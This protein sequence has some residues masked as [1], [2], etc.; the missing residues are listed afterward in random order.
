MKYTKMFSS[1]VA[2]TMALM[3]SLGASTASATT[4]Y[5]EGRFYREAMGAGSTLSFSSWGSTRL[6]AGSTTLNTC[7]WGGIGGSILSPGGSGFSVDV[8]LNSFSWENCSSPTYTL[9][10]GT[11]LIDYT[12]YTEAVVHSSN[13]K[14]TVSLFGTSCV[15]GTG[16]YFDFGRLTTSSYGSATLNI[17]STVKEQEPLKWICPDT[18]V[19]TGTYRG[20]S[21]YSLWVE[22]W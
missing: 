21:P 5:K 1:I 17:K 8:S 16:T 13:F 6:E 9:A 2:V 15:Y 12:I 10:G 18:A 4:L 11:I 7:T 22:E 3:V 19:L 20:T 14:F